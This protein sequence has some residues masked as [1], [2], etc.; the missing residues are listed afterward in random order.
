MHLELGTKKTGFPVRAEQGAQC[1]EASAT[2]CGS[3][4]RKNKNIETK[5]KPTAE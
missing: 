3:K 2:K 5:I 4:K 1:A